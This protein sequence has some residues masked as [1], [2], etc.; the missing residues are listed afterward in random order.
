MC[1]VRARTFHISDM[2]INKPIH[3]THRRTFHS[4]E[5]SRVSVYAYDAQAVHVL[6]RVHHS[7]NTRFVCIFAQRYSSAVHSSPANV[8]VLVS[9]DIAT[10][11]FSAN[12]RWMLTVAAVVR[13]IMNNLFTRCAIAKDEEARK[14][15]PHR[16]TASIGLAKPYQL[17]YYTRIEYTHKQKRIR[18][19]GNT[20]NRFTRCCRIRRIGMPVR[21]PAC[22]V[23]ARI[24]LAALA[25][26]RLCFC[27]W[28]KT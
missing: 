18:A 9:V 14:S 27:F 6:A 16:I 7:S 8:Y 23:H 13:R 22:I 26:L 4:N 2:Y 19:H 1:T 5:Y 28:Q 17:P 24:A 12:E 20:E 15:Q 3:S 10:H 21:M 11:R 25:R